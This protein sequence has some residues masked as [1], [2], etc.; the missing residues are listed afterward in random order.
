MSCRVMSSH[1]VTCQH[2]YSTITSHSAAAHKHCDPVQHSACHS[3]AA[4]SRAMSKLAATSDKSD[5]RACARLRHGRDSSFTKQACH[6]VAGSPDSAAA[7]CDAAAA[8]AACTTMAGLHKEPRSNQ[9][10]DPGSSFLLS[11][12]PLRGMTSFQ[13]AIRACPGC[14]QGVRRVCRCSC[15]RSSATHLGHIMLLQLHL[16]Q[17]CVCGM[18]VV[19]ACEAGPCLSFEQFQEGGIAVRPPIQA[20]EVCG[21]CRNGTTNNTLLLTAF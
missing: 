13:L 15:M 7:R 6:S 21:I 18:L 1:L 17:L 16:G 3:A 19:R 9:S 2:G 20:A 12:M 10:E 14:V 4:H 11:P 8:Q 5:H